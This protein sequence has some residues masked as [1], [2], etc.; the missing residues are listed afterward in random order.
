MVQRPKA[1]IPAEIRNERTE[2]ISV[3]SVFYADLLGAIAQRAFK[4]AYV[5]QTAW[6]RY[7]ASKP[8]GTVAFRARRPFD[9]NDAGRGYDAPNYRYWPKKGRR[10]QTNSL[11]CILFR[12]TRDSLINFRGA[13]RDREGSASAPIGGGS[14]SS[15]IISDVRFAVALSTRAISYGFRTTEVSCRTRR[16][17]DCRR[18]AGSQRGVVVRGSF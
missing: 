18:A 11:G 14:V 9:F 13:I 8:H 7:D 17:I 6:P 2:F 10:C 15:I 3:S 16:K 5:H 1:I 4:C 12:E